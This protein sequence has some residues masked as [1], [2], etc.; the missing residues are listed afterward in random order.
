MEKWI[1]KLERAQWAG[2][3]DASGALSGDGKDLGKVPRKEEE[4][5]GAAGKRVFQHAD[6]DEGR[7]EAWEW[8]DDIY[9]VDSEHITGAET[10]GDRLVV[11]SDLGDEENGR[12]LYALTKTREVDGTI[13]V[14]FDIFGPNPLGVKSVDDF[15]EKYRK[16]TGQDLELDS[17]P[18]SESDYPSERPEYFEDSL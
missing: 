6:M 18:D 13:E 14:D 10:S 16:M 7:L 2:L 8:D 11:Y 12:I 5:S 9:V 15:K 3:K 17:L 4:P 1:E